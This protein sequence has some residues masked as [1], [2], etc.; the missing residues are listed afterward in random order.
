MGEC[1]GRLVMAKYFLTDCMVDAILFQREELV[2]MSLEEK[3]D[4]VIRETK[5]RLQIKKGDEITL[6]ILPT[7]SILATIQR[8]LKA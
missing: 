4:Y 2:G 6:S 1:D 7:G 8:Y 3:M 5:E